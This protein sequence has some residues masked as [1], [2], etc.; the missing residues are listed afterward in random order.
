MYLSVRLSFRSDASERP[1]DTEG[2]YDNSKRSDSCGGV[3]R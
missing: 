2:H 1:T 3:D